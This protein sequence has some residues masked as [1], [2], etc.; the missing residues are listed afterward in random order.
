MYKGYYDKSGR[1]LFCK[2]PYF[3]V[4][5]NNLYKND[6]YT[7]DQKAA[8]KRASSKELLLQI[9]GETKFEKFQFMRGMGYSEDEIIKHL[10]IPSKAAFKMLDQ[11]ATNLVEAYL[12]YQARSGHVQNLVNA[13]KI[14]WKSVI[15]LE[16]RAMVVAKYCDK[17]PG[18][19]KLAYAESHVRQTLN[20]AVQIVTEMQEKTPLA[21]AF[22]KFI[23]DNVVQGGGTRKGSNQ[24]P[25]TPKELEN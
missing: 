23:K 10:N 13:L 16:K 17:K 24:L 3:I 20:V 19:R 25:V 6:A 22:N 18:D 9:P 15:A 14:Q 4:A 21:M 8:P 12:S 5:F 7:G 2:S 11:K 1:L